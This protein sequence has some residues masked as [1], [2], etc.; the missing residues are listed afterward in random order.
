MYKKVKDM[1]FREYNQKFMLVKNTGN[2]LKDTDIVEPFWAYMYIDN[3]LGTIMVILG[4]EENGEKYIHEEFL[5]NAL[6]ERIKD[7]QVKIID[8]TKYQYANLVRSIYEECSLVKKSVLYT[9]NMKKLDKFRADYNPDVVSCFIKSASGKCTN[10]WAKIKGYI[11]ESD[12]FIVGPLSNEP[13]S[14]YVKHIIYN[15]TE[16]L[17]MFKPDNIQE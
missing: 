17:V 1:N 7:F 16:M 10:V 13:I 15:N 5:L 6:Y 3:K 2:F 4:N 9:R 14:V 8:D 12:V 11:E